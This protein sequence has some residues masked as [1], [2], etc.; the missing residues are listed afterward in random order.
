MDGDGAQLVHTE[1]RSE[2]G[3]GIVDT[4]S[5][6]R[7]DV[8]DREVARVGADLDRESRGA[9]AGGEG[10]CVRGECSFRTRGAAHRGD[11]DQRRTGGQR[12]AQSARDGLRSSASR[13][14]ARGVEN[15]SS[16][17]EDGNHESVHPGRKLR[18]GGTRTGTAE[19]D[20]ARVGARGNSECGSRLV[21]RE[22]HV[23]GLDPGHVGHQSD[24]EL[25]VGVDGVLECHH[26]NGAL[27]GGDGRVGDVVSDV[28]TVVDVDVGVVRGLELRSVDFVLDFHISR[29][30]AGQDLESLPH[31]ALEEHESLNASVVESATA[32]GGTSGGI[33]FDGHLDS[34]VLLGSSGKR[35]VDHF[36][37]RAGVGVHSVDGGVVDGDGV[38]SVHRDVQVGRSRE[39]LCGGAAGDHVRD[40]GSAGRRWHLQTEW[41]RTK[42]L[43]NRESP[44]HNHGAVLQDDVPVVDRDGDV[45][46]KPSRN[47]SS[48]IVAEN[49]HLVCVC[50]TLTGNG[51]C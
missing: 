17:G 50:F 30:G 32:E 45:E 49:S 10:Q 28:L 5:R 47:S 21:D 35:D 42:V 51:L 2:S 26:D 27:T 46:V 14:N 43:Q 1:P 6:E 38:L 25:G 18:L 19:S 44:L 24:R 8:V 40:V 23:F 34:E 15:N 29:E 37:R 48:S 13:E 20:E 11:D 33:S 36:A 31:I 4:A 7:H 16:R 12:G 22:G 9:L 39:T 3:R 41:E